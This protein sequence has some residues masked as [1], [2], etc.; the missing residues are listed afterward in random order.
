[1]IDGI[2]SKIFDGFCYGVGFW[3]VPFILFL[4]FMLGFYLLDLV[5]DKRKHKQTPESKVIQLEKK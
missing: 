4:I 5:E 1:M 3:C 2:M